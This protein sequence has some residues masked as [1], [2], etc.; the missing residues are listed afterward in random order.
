MLS[1]LHACR[2]SLKWPQ[3]ET[4]FVVEHTHAG[5]SDTR[6]GSLE[7]ASLENTVRTRAAAGMSVEWREHEARQ[8]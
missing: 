3:M 1:F 4:Y 8:R 6:T 7:N 5:D 2:Q